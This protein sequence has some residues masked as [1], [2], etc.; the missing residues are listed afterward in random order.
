MPVLQ[1][2]SIFLSTFNFRVAVSTSDF[3]VHQNLYSSKHNEQLFLFKC[4][5]HTNSKSL[6]SKAADQRKL[7][8][9]RRKTHNVYGS[10]GI[11]TQTGNRC[12][13]WT[14][15]GIKEQGRQNLKKSY[16]TP[17][18]LQE[19]ACHQGRVRQQE[20]NER[21]LRASDLWR[22]GRVK[23]KRIHSKIQ[24]FIMRNLRVCEQQE[25][26]I[27]LE[28][29]HG[30]APTQISCQQ[31]VQKKNFILLKNE[32]LCKATTRKLRENRYNGR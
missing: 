27:G 8:T 18:Y 13:Y 25:F 15:F 29:G 2:Q 20:C 12:F 9:L 5:I 26:L 7:Q 11:S 28:P 6:T 4:N 10:T 31:L 14:Q 1:F 17:H 23:A 3:K 24:S 19:A 30:I 21:C 16:S 32:H 22:L